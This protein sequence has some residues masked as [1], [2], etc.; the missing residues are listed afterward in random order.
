S[1][2]DLPMFS[3][4]MGTTNAPSN[5]TPER[6]TSVSALNLRNLGAL[7][8]LALLDGHRVPPTSALGFVDIN[9][10]PTMLLER[11]D[12]VTGGASAVY[13]S[14]AVTGVINFVLDRDFDGLRIDASGGIS[15]YGDAL[16]GNFGIA[17]GTT[18][19]ND[20]GHV[21]ASFQHR[22]DDGI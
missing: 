11:V 15:E 12:V 20:R 4:S 1:L 5:N 10:L 6:N 17:G 8:G 14:D 19:A 3:G 22:Y 18:F 13:G 16:T 7:R 9:S 2:T 21:M